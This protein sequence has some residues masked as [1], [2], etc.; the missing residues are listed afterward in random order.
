MLG[1]ELEQGKGGRFKQNQIALSDFTRPRRGRDASHLR[2]HECVQGLAREGM[3]VELSHASRLNF[4]AGAEAR[5]TSTL[6]FS[7]A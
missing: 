2:P 7:Q 3:K 6:G 5:A 1:Q 4:C